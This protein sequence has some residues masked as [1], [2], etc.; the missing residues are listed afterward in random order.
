MRPPTR[1]ATGTP[2]L[3]FRFHY[4]AERSSQ[5][6]IDLGAEAAKQGVSFDP[7]TSLNV[8]TTLDADLGLG[9]TLGSSERFFLD[10][11]SFDLSATNTADDVIV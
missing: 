10:V 9:M 1:P 5:F 2:E 6:N 7:G 3:R 4:A 11:D 8:T